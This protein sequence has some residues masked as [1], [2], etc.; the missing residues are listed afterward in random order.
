MNKHCL[1]KGLN[2]HLSCDLKGSWPCR[3]VGQSGCIAYQRAV[4]NPGINRCVFL[5][6][7]F[8][9]ELS[10]ALVTVF[11]CSFPFSGDQEDPISQQRLWH[12]LGLL[13]GQ[14]PDDRNRNR[15]HPLLGYPSWKISGVDDEQ[16]SGG[17]AQGFQGLD[18]ERVS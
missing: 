11:Q 14:H 16:Q 8:C 9:K 18:G 10:S 17:L 13:Q 5:Y 7:R 4:S 3:L 15:P 2:F 6:S 12:P 1:I